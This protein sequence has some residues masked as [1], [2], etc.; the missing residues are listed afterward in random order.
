MFK[1]SGIVLGFLALMTAACQHNTVYE[2]F[3]VFEDGQ[4]IADS[5]LVFDFTIDDNA[6]PYQLNYHVRN[7]IDYPFYNLYV[8]YELQDSTGKIL[9]ASM[10]ET[11][12]MDPMTGR[13]LG[14][15]IGDF[16]NHDITLKPEHRFPYNGKYQFQIKQYMRP[17][18]LLQIHA[19]GFS[20]QNSAQ[21]N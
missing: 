18:T 4:W 20:V 5:V 14:E 2:S 8:K 21:A 10:H 3:R 15:G 19:V 6:Q 11:T 9:E 1:H 7:T 17:D 16:Y 12:L 13:P